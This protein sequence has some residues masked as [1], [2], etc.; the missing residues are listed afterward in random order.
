MKRICKK[1]RIRICRGI[2]MSKTLGDINEMR[3][4]V[5]INDRF[6]DTNK[7]KRRKN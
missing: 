6:N 3:E 2:A 5:G 4:I 1:K 7:R